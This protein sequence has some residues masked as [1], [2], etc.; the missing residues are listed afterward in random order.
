MLTLKQIQFQKYVGKGLCTFDAQERYFNY[1]YTVKKLKFED[2]L[3][4]I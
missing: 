2:S 4:S 3:K 1:H